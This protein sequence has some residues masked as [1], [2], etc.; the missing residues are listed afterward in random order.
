MVKAESRVGE[1]HGMLTIK[2]IV[3][4]NSISYAV[5]EC[6]CG[7]EKV[8][9]VGN[10]VTGEVKSCGC[11]RSI[12][13]KMHGLNNSR[14]QRV[15]NDMI[16]RCTNKNRHNYKNYGGRGINVCEEWLSLKNFAEWA[17]LN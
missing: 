3:K 15:H 1:T 16:Q 7:N 10:L 2:S 17:Y 5:C 6:K 11:I 4:K 9:R 13:A 14:I 8:A 12:S